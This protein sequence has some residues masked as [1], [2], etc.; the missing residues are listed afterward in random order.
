MSEVIKAVEQ[1]HRDLADGHAFMPGRTAVPF[2]ASAAVMI[3]M[4]ASSER[5]HALG[6]KVM[7]DVPH[8]PAEG[9][10]RQQSVIMLVDPVMGSC[11]AILDGAVITRMRTAAVSAVATAHL[12]NESAETLGLIGAGALARTH[13]E[14]ICQVRQIS[15]VVVWSRSPSTA[16]M[17]VDSQKDG[18]VEIVAAQSVRAVVD[19]ADVLCTLTPS[20]DPL[21]HG[22]WLREGTHLN[23]VG[24]PPRPSYREVDT[25]AIARCRV[26]VDDLAV[27]TEESGA[28]VM[29]VSE[30]GIGT[31]A[32]VDLGEVIAGK[33]PGRRHQEETTMFVS[34][35]LGNQDV[36]TARLVVDT[37]RRMGL[38]VDADLTV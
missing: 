23:V 35:G 36:V 10:P 18:N 34:V 24:A 11:E 26:V 22:S 21:I 29:A 37:V 12:A 3:P 25:G 15:R 9:R 4:V 13:M 38:G 2:A 31:D 32:L 14:A 8:N 1:A 20:V 16:Q 6:L 30:G 19:T 7:T 27:A 33:Q 5:Q 17:F 28:I